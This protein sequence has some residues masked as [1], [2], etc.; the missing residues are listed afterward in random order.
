MRRWVK[1][2]ASVLAILVVASGAGLTSL[3]AK[4]PEVPPP[5]NMT[6]QATPEKVAAVGDEAA[7][8]DQ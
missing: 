8:N 4:Y 1:A 5:E 2:L 7:D 6:V 3:F